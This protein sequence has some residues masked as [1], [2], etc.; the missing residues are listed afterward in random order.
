MPFPLL[1]LDQQS[2]PQPQSP[3]PLSEQKFTTGAIAQ[4]QTHS[5]SPQPHTLQSEHD[6]LSERTDRPRSNSAA[7]ATIRQSVGP[8]EHSGIVAAASPHERTEHET[9]DAMQS[10][11]QQPPLLQRP[12]SRT[13]T[14]GGLRCALCDHS[15]H[16]SGYTA[17]AAQPRRRYNGRVTASRLSVR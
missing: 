10:Q 8:L 4:R 1:P 3:Q 6:P 17:T 12:H 15:D 7:A 5:P 2:Q 13:L 14:G 9:S 16:H 11:K